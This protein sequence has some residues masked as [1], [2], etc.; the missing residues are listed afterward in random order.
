MDQ[1]G[2][3]IFKNGGAGNAVGTE[4][5]RITSDGKIG[6]NNSSPLYPMHFK[7]AMSSSPSFIH[8]EVTGSNAVGGGG[9]IA[10]DTSASNNAST[11]ISRFV[12]SLCLI[13]FKPRFFA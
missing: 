11:S 3:Y 4:K 10:F 2:N 5:L 7:N 12:L 13:T 8:M 9:G 1:S 6:I